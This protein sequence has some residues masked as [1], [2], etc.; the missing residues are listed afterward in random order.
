MISACVFFP[1]Q[2]GQAFLRLIHFAVGHG[3][4]GTDALFQR[5]GTA[6]KMFVTGFTSFLSSRK[7]RAVI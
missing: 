4:Y 1:G 6:A 2:P 5:S 7:V 3:F